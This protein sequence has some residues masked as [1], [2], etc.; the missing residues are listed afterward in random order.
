MREKKIKNSGRNVKSKISG[1]K[2]YVDEQ[3]D[4]FTTKKAKQ[5]K[6]LGEI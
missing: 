1:R 5:K 4:I 6:K 2:I 3:N